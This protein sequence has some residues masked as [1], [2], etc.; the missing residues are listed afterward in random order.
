MSQNVSSAAVV[1]GALRVKMTKKTKQTKT[2]PELTP[3][4]NF[5]E[6]I[7]K[8]GKTGFYDVTAPACPVAHRLNELKKNP[9]T[10]LRR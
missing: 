3:C 9:E 5:L 2:L 7:F 8:N 6:H 4:P 10:V 1:I